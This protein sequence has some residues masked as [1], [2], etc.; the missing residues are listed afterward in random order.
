VQL[1][2]RECR[3]STHV[4][5]ASLDGG[6]TT[7]S[8]IRQ[9]LSLVHPMELVSSKKAF[10]LDHVGWF[11]KGLLAAFVSQGAVAVAFINRGCF[12]IIYT[13]PSREMPRSLGFNRE[14]EITLTTNGLFVVPMHL[15]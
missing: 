7:A 5:C 8:D 1:D 12:S 13:S 15:S 2:T 4:L 3:S 10:R 14:A 6:N 11:G 9:H